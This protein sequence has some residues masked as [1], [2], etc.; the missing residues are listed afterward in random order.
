M[1]TPTVMNMIYTDTTQTPV[2]QHFSRM[3]MRHF[4]LRSS[5]GGENL[6]IVA[7]LGGK[8]AT[9][10][11]ALA[12]TAAK[13]SGVKSVNV[14]ATVPFHFEGEN[15][16]SSAALA[17]QRLSELEEVKTVVFN[18][19]DLMSK[20][21]NLNFFNAFETADKEIMHIIENLT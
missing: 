10:F 17:A 11:T 12:A 15:R 21:P 2:N 13:D 1:S 14:V 16:I 3:R 9:K 19:D 7:G 18:N 8:T 4:L 5:R 20:Y 6:V